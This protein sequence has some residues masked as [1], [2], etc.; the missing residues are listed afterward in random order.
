MKAQNIERQEANQNEYNRYIVVYGEAFCTV[1]NF[2]KL[3]FLANRSLQL[4]CFL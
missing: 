3:Q 4:M 2:T 1:N